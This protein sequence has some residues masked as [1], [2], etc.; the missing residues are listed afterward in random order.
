MALLEA[1]CPV[2]AIANRTPE[3]SARLAD[4]LRARFPQADV[5][6]VPFDGVAAVAKD[7][8]LLV[9]AT[10]VGLH[11]DDACLLP[12]TCFQPGQLVY[13][14]VYR[15]LHTPFLQAAQRCGATVIPGLDMLIGQGAVA[16]H[17]WTGLTF[18]VA[19]IRQMLQPLLHTP[20]L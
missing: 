8:G 17:I 4:A 16:F 12:S 1:G 2:L 6:T 19:E 14:I 18:P 20:T 13:D 9:N 5:R 7:Y 11:H 15:P 10:A 3:R